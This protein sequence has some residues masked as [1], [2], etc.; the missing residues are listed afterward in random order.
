MGKRM[1]NTTKI[2]HLIE[3]LD[4]F[5]PGVVNGRFWLQHTSRPAVLPSVLPLKI[6]IIIKLNKNTSEIFHQD[7]PGR[8][9]VDLMTPYWTEHMT[10]EAHGRRTGPDLQRTACLRS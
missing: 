1:S 8:K 5:L 6:I 9:Y 3:K 10:I 4:Y 7:K 2:V